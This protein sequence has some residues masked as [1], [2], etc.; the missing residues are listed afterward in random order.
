MADDWRIHIEVGEADG[1][2]DRL[3]DALGG[4]AAELAGELEKRRLAVSRDGVVVWVAPEDI[5]A[6]EE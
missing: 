1:L 3:G 2:L 4:D 6:G 5:P